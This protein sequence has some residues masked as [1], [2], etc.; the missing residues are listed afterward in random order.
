MRVRPSVLTNLGQMNTREK[1]V[2]NGRA[3]RYR[4]ELGSSV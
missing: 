1:K 4:S 2:Q 3:K